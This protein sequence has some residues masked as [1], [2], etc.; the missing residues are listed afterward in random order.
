MRV[1]RTTLTGTFVQLEPIQPSHFSE[2]SAVA[3]DR[4]IWETTPLGPS[5]EAYFETLVSLAA[6]GRQVPFAVRWR[7]SGQLVGGTRLMD[8]VPEHYR[9]EIGG[10]WYHPDYWGGPVNPDAKRL[11][12]SHAFDVCGANRVQLLTDVINQRSQAAIAKLGAVRE[13]VVRSHML[14]DGTRRR[15]SVMF[16]IVRE[17]WP[18]VRAQLDAVIAAS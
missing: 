1:E 13:G 14:I 4:R 3:A 7:E 12:L 17:E 18:T 2:L 8:I 6:E 16:S 5:F 15:D 9:L 10:T 11:L